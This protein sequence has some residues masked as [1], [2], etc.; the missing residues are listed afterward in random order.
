MYSAVYEQLKKLKNGTEDETNGR[1]IV[2]PWAI[3]FCRRLPTP[4]VLDVGAGRGADLIA[5]R[6]SVPSAELSAIESFPVSVELLKRQGVEVSSINLERDRFPFP[7]G[8]FNVVICNQV[9]E[10]LKEIFWALS[11]ISRVAADDGLIILGVPNLGS[12]HNRT[13]LLFGKQ[14][15]AIHVVG[16][17]VRG[18][19]IDGFRSFVEAGGALKI[20]AV[21]GANFYPL[22]KQAARF[23]SKTLPGLSVSAFFRVR[24]VKG[25]RNYIDVLQ[26]G[27][28][29]ALADTPYFTG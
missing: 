2:L 4:R 21:A 24:K 18:F 11:E 28:S 12:A 22:P 16:P 19:T 3:D 1:H 29:K 8:A 6:D 20:E 10:H 7:D 9:L 15:P 14:P 26:S 27:Q 25:A 17:H 13:A 5:I 23:M